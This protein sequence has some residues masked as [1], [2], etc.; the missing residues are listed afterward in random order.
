MNISTTVIS[1]PDDVTVCVGEGTVLLNCTLSSDNNSIK[2][3][4]VQ[5]YRTIYSTNTT[6]ILR[7]GPD[8]DY[9]SIFITTS[10]KDNLTF[11]TLSFA[12]VTKSIAGYYWVGLSSDDV[13]NTSLSVQSM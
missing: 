4:D 7:I 3:D 12:N 6:K 2:I 8:G 10:T 9:N 11:T 5:W 13:C 1:E